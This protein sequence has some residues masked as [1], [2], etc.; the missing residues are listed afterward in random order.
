MFSVTDLFLW[1]EFMNKQ[2]RWVAIIS[3]TL[4]Y[5]LVAAI[6][7]AMTCLLLAGKES[8]E[9]SKLDQLQEVIR[10]RFIGQEDLTRMQDAAAEAMVEAL[11]DR[12][13]YYI[14]ASEYAAYEEQKHNQYVGIGATITVTEGDQGFRVS[15]IEAD[16]SAKEAGI[17][18]GDIIIK[19]DSTSVT[20]LTTAG[21]RDLVRGEEGTFVALTVLRDG[22]QKVFSVERKTIKVVVAEGEMLENNI[23]L[24]RIKNFDERCAQ[25]TI[26]A[27]EKLVEN[28]A[29]ALIFDLRNNPGGYKSELVKVLDYLLPKGPLFR[30]L[31]YRGYEAVDSSDERCLKL[32]MAVLVNGESYSAAEFFAAALDEYDWAVVVGEATTGKGYFQ[33]TYMLNDGSAVGLS[34]GKYFTPNGVSLAEVGGLIPEV[35]V[36]VDEETAALIYADLVDPQDDPQIQAA[37]NALK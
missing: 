33:N 5:V 34:V 18:P 14:P 28:G 22:E 35:L 17:L 9:Q 12:W 16:G 15:R 4:C 25:D 10:T 30:S 23:G 19:I 2:K 37:V 13:S 11:G 32:P 7:S 27:I 26:T 24:V 6:S 1:G 31:D 36:Q 21:A 3:K 20:G 8:S 29:K